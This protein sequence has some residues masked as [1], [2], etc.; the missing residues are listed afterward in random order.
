MLF[1]SRAKYKYTHSVYSEDAMD[2]YTHAHTNRAAI[3]REGDRENQ[4]TNQWKTES[5]IVYKQV[6]KTN[7]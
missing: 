2:M 4:L 1:L 7:V 6:V 5:T 3:Q